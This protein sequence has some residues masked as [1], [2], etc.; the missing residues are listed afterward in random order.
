MRWPHGSDFNTRHRFNHEF[1]WRRAIYTKLNNENWLAGICTVLLVAI[2]L[3]AICA[4][5]NAQ[6][7]APAVTPAVTPAVAPATKAVTTIPDKPPTVPDAFRAT[8]WRDLAEMTEAQRQVDGLTQIVNKAKEKIQADNK[9]LAE[10]C[11]DQFQVTVSKEGEPGC[12]N[13]T[14]ASVAQPS[15]AQAK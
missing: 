7:V 14:S 15:S 1:N 10:I 12:T 8:F 11:T 4:M 5:G 13:K 9:R 2:G 3:I 6:E